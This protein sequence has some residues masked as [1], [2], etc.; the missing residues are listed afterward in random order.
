MSLTESRLDQNVSS[1]M[2]HCG[3]KILRE[4]INLGVTTKY[5][6]RK[7]IISFLKTKS[8]RK[9]GT[10][11]IVQLSQMEENCREQNLT[12]F[13]KRESER[14]ERNSVVFLF[15]TSNRYHKTKTF[16]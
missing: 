9:N 5:V 6:Q 7:R 10:K 15:N 11:K 13:W 4:T 3:S 1:P 8:L 16:H 14:E 2:A 12:N